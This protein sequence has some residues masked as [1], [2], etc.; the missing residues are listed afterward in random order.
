MSLSKEQIRK[1]FNDQPE[2]FED[3]GNGFSTIEKVLENQEEAERQALENA[4]AEISL[5]VYSKY[6]DIVDLEGND[7]YDKKDSFQDHIE[8]TYLDNETLKSIYFDGGIEMIVGCINMKEIL[9]YYHP[10]C[11]RVKSQWILDEFSGF[12]N[13]EEGE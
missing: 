12:K 13:K 4:K 6:N 5:D 8:E 11:Y 10:G 2:L 1:L 7:Y 3:G 9:E